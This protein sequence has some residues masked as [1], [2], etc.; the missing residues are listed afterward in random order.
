MR[1]ERGA[2]LAAVRPGGCPWGPGAGSVEPRPGP[3]TEASGERMSGA[4]GLRAAPGGPGLR[5]AA[6]RSHRAPRGRKGRGIVTGGN[7]KAAGLP[8]AT[9]RLAEREER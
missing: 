8:G 4:P 7:G 9:W 1:E 5:G 2:V 3:G 6:P